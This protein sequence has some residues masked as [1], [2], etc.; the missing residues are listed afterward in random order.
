MME[1]KGGNLGGILGE[2]KSGGSNQNV[3]G[4]VPT[5]RNIR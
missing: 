3:E 2:K 4:K 5:W 1:G